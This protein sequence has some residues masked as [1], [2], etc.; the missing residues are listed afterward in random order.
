MSS[1]ALQWHFAPVS[2]P[3]YLPQANALSF[4]VEAISAPPASSML[5]VPVGSSVP[6]CSD[7][8]RPE[9][10]TSL[11]LMFMTI[12]V[13]IKQ[14]RTLGGSFHFYLFG[15]KVNSYKG[16]IVN[17]T[18]CIISRYMILVCSMSYISS[19]W[20]GR[21]ICVHLGQGGGVFVVM[22]KLKWGIQVNSVVV[23][24]QG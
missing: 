17:N 14:M 21:G 4:V 5:A 6:F 1:Q 9:D 2:C 20:S 15:F 23:R 12:H 7:A 10:S 13:G 18:K 19:K 24:I 16:C 11:A 8:L 22:R 3:Y